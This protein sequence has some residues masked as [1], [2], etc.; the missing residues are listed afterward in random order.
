MILEETNIR[1]SQAFLSA[2]LLPE[3]VRLEPIVMSLGWTC[4]FRSVFCRSV[5]LIQLQAPA[6]RSTRSVLTT[7]ICGSFTNHHLYNNPGFPSTLRQFNVVIIVHTRFMP[8]ML[9]ACPVVPAFPPD[10]PLPQP[11]LL[12]SP[13]GFFSCQINL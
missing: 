12:F 11:C 4:H 2:V 3:Q 13:T 8:L 9:Q 6:F 10:S 1:S 7:H 5:P